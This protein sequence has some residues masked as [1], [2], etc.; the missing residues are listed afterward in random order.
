[1]RIFGSIG[2]MVLVA[3]M[4]VGLLGC[5]SSSS[6]AANSKGGSKNVDG[7]VKVYIDG[8]DVGDKQDAATLAK[9]V[10]DRLI[11]E[12]NIQVVDKKDADFSITICPLP[13]TKINK[14]LN[15]NYV[16]V[17]YT[18]SRFSNK[19]VIPNVALRPVDELKEF[20]KDTIANH[21]IKVINEPPK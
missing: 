18:V 11:T 5:N 16:M 19:E 17:S 9:A 20:A 6:T 14:A 12:K 1:M 10:Y 8:V 2:K 21:F 13:V 7:T 4:V 3:V 15:I